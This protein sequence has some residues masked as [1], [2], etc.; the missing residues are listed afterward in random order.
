[1]RNIEEITLIGYVYKDPSFP[2]KARYPNWIKGTLYVN[3]KHKGKDGEEIKL[4]NWYDFSTNSEG[5][6]KVMSEYVKDKCAVMIRG[7]P[8]ARA[9]KDQEGNAKASI[10]VHVNDLNILSYPKEEGVVAKSN[11]VNA[12]PD[13]DDEIPF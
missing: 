11:S 4:A 7:V 12:K 9:Y 3:R 2:D 10:D 8:K 6:V 5:M 13:F 1:M